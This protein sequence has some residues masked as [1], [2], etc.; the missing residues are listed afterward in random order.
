MAVRVVGTGLAALCVIL[1]VWAAVYWFN[2]SDQIPAALV[3]LML[4]VV[5]V[6]TI[7]CC[8]VIPSA[9]IALATGAG[10]AV[11]TV[12]VSLLYGV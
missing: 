9:G 2:L 12:M 3:S 10:L 5:S 1:H 11:I 6:L 4:G 8:W 7:V